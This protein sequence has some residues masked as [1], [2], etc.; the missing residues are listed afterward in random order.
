LGES[1][2]NKQCICGLIK[3]NGGIYLNKRIIVVEGYLASGKSTFARQL[4]NVAKVPY[5][6]KDTFKIALCQNI[7]VV[8]RDES[9]RFSL[10][11]FDAMMYVME[12]LF[13]SGYPL[14]I[15][16]NFVPLGVKR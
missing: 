8:G 4:S 11:T 15:E 13:E 6:I 10:V 16:G 2:F 1:I 5:L 14:I 12:R 3:I 7:T 9:S